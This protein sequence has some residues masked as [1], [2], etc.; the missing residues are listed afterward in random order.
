MVD[1]KFNIMKLREYSSLKVLPHVKY[2]LTKQGFL[3]HSKLC[4]IM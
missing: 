4:Y 3:F 2:T 1:I